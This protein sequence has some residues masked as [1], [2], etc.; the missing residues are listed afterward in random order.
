LD[1]KHTEKRPEPHHAERTPESARPTACPRFASL[2]LATLATLALLAR[3]Q[4]ARGE[5]PP[6]PSDALAR[7][8][9]EAW[10]EQLY[11]FDALEAYRSTDGGLVTEFVIARRWRDGQAQLLIDVRSPPGDRDVALLFLQRRDRSDDVFLLPRDAPRALKSI[12]RRTAAQ[13]EVSVPGLASRL[14]LL[15]LRP[16]A[17]GELAYRWLGEEQVDGVSCYLL[18]GRPEQRDLGFDRVEL[19]I[20]AQ[21]GGALRTRYFRR[22]REFRRVSSSATDFGEFDGRRLPE[23]RRIE[24]PPGRPPLVLELRNAVVEPPLPD[25]LFTRRSLIVQRFPSF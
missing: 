24:S 11:G 17:P 15:D 2:A 23:R 21:D 6:S 22:G 8:L 10:F 3:P 18:E 9:A 5:E 7:E 20:S 4:L 19:A 1:P 25:S 16:I 14:A 12:E 13:L